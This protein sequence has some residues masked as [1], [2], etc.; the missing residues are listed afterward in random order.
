MPE[1]PPTGGEPLPPG[2]AAAIQRERAAEAIRAYAT[3]ASAY[4]NRASP[5]SAPF[6]TH[7]REY[8]ITDTSIE[9]QPSMPNPET[10]RVPPDA[11][12]NIHRIA[13][14]LS[15]ILRPNMVQPPPLP[16]PRRGPLD[17]TDPAWAAQAVPVEP[18]GIS[19]TNAWVETTDEEPDEDSDEDDSG[20]VDFDD[21]DSGEEEEGPAVA[22]PQEEVPTIV[23][24]PNQVTFGVEIECLLRI[25]DME[26]ARQQRGEYRR[27]VALLGVAPRRTGAWGLQSDGSVRTSNPDYHPVEVVSP[28]LC[29]AQ[30]LDSVH[31]VVNHLRNRLGGRVNSSCGVHVHIGWPES[32]G[33][34]HIQRLLHLVAHFEPA[35][36]ACTGTANRE[37]NRYCTPLKCNAQTEDNAYRE[38][39]PSGSPRALANHYH[40]SRYFAVSINNILMPRTEE[41]GERRGG[42]SRTQ[43]PQGLI[44]CRGTVEFRLWSGS[45]NASKILAW[46]NLSASIVQLALGSDDLRP[47]T[48]DTRLIEAAEGEGP[49]EKAVRVMLDDLWGPENSSRLRF[50]VE[51][52]SYNA[53]GYATARRM[54]LRLARRYDLDEPHVAV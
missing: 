11:A 16:R 31:E 15:R 23:L 34:V 40:A 52:P 10:P 41:D 47:W 32:A 48:T 26:S 27:P 39:P 19:G 42:S 17:E 28:V 38:S 5:A 7:Q 1:Q 50:G 46:I 12:E 21:E 37:R 2:L 24:A 18:V 51:H 35:L 29:G 22:E 25:R 45:L 14:D 43:N 54:L 49:G 13:E 36:F 44:R 3:T 20:S 8:M 33:V 53:N 4:W 9:A 30:D 6:P